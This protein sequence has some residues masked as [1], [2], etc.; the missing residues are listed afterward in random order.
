MGLFRKK[1][2]EVRPKTKTLEEFMA[3]MDEA[4][5][6]S[7]MPPYDYLPERALHKFL[8]S[9]GLSIARSGNAFMLE[10]ITPDKLS[11]ENCFTNV[12]EM[13]DIIKPITDEKIL[14]Y[15]NFYGDKDVTLE[16]CLKDRQ[17]FYGRTND[18]DRQ[19]V[20]DNGLQWYEMADLVVNK[21]WYI[22]LEEIYQVCYDHDIDLEQELLKLKD[23]EAF[24]MYY[25]DE[26]VDKMVEFF[27]Q[28][29]EDLDGN[30][31]MEYS[32]TLRHSHHRYEDGKWQYCIVGSINGVTLDR[33]KEE[34][35][36]LKDENTMVSNPYYKGDFNG[37]YTIKELDDWIQKCDYAKAMK[38]M[39]KKVTKAK[40]H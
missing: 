12:K 9:S 34:L 22:N 16:F 25:F 3:I 38:A 10:G 1:K 27:A 11:G 33:V 15:L 37:R 23:N 17:A 5:P 28:K 6:S 18:T 35:E 4:I 20:Y 40:E 29:G 13:F 7:I 32:L 26:D 21:A 8:V 2:A 31:S 19:L 30:P 24:G 39:L 14:K 36:T